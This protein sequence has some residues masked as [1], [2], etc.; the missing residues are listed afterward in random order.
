M[1]TFLHHMFKASNFWTMKGLVKWIQ[2]LKVDFW[3]SCALNTVFTE[4]WIFKFRNQ[5]HLCLLS[6]RL[7]NRAY[8]ILFMHKTAKQVCTSSKCQFNQCCKIFSS[9]SHLRRH[10]SVCGKLISEKLLFRLSICQ[11]WPPDFKTQCSHSITSMA[12]LV[13]GIITNEI[14]ARGF[15]LQ[16][17]GGKSNAQ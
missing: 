16:E 15:K 12:G 2:N 17:Y 7:F 8:Y 13:S 9:S 4:Y 11:K 10:E 6:S 14:V 1:W 3:R 5:F